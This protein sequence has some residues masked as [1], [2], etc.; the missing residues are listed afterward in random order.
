MMM[1]DDD[2]FDVDVVVFAFVIAIIVVVAVV[3][4]FG[5]THRMQSCRSM[6]ANGYLINS[7]IHA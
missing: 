5:K 1:D 6:L 3:V 2:D 4:G 7:G